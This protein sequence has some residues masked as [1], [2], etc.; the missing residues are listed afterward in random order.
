MVP[1]R[2]VST[3]G[4]RQMRWSGVVV[5]FINRFL[6]QNPGGHGESSLR[7]LISIVVPWIAGIYL[8][9]RLAARRGPDAVPTGPEFGQSLGVVWIGTLL[10]TFLGV[11]PQ[12]FSWLLWIGFVTLLATAAVA[13]VVASQN[14]L[15]SE[16]REQAKWTSI[17][18]AG[19]AVA[20]WLAIGTLEIEIPRLSSKATAEEIADAY[21]SRCC[22][23][24]LNYDAVVRNQ[25]FFGNREDRVKA[26]S[27]GSG[28]LISNDRTR[29]LIVTNR[30][31]VDPSMSGNH[32]DHLELGIKLASSPGIVRGKIAAIHSE[33]DLALV[34]V[35]FDFPR[36]G[37]VQMA[38]H[39]GV[40]QGE[41]AVAI[42]NPLGLESIISQGIISGRDDDIVATTCPIS[43]G[44]SGGGLF[45][46]RSGMLA[47]FNTMTLTQGQNLNF[48]IPAEEVLKA[49]DHDRWKWV[50]CQA[51]TLALARLIPRPSK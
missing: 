21:R 35:E 48:A 27:T 22:K 47:G 19:L 20:S 1:G 36:R 11:V 4:G 38:A 5:Q 46:Y 13:A 39:S 25:G 51:E 3:E 31:V 40:R 44:N 7:W 28:V 16:G 18:S 14:T 30:H 8:L 45:L 32:A 23:L 17:G 42:G 43:P 10:L 33:T 29:G 2:L 49:F 41:G 24:V 50:A 9:N 6:N 34:I 15:S 37:A 12:G 26:G